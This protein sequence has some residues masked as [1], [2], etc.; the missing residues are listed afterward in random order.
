MTADYVK[1]NY[2]IHNES[3]SLN[4]NNYVAYGTLK[5][6]VT[7]K[8]LKCDESA[9]NNYKLTKRKK[10]EAHHCKLKIQWNPKTHAAKIKHLSP[11]LI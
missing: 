10:Y 3:T 11:R 9:W 6:E 2:L 7:Y 1:D 5:S 8:T 4:P